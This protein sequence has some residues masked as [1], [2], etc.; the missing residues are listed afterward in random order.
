[1]CKPDGRDDRRHADIRLL[2][3]HRDDNEKQRDADQIAGEAR[4]QLLLREQPGGDD[5]KGRLDEF[6]GL[7]RQ[8]GQVDPASRALDLDAN[9]ERSTRAATSE[10][11]KPITAMRRMVRGGCSETANMRPIANGSIA[12]WRRTKCSPS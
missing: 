5:G 2:D 1:M 7:Q 8:P 4:A 3:Q 12:R 10:I 9:D 6:G 11:A